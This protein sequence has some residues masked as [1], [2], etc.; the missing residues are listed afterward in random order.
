M[1]PFLFKHVSTKKMIFLSI[2]TT[3]LLCQSCAN[4][5]ETLPRET[6]N[7]APESGLLSACIKVEGKVSGDLIPNSTVSLYETSSVGYSIVMTE[8]R[9]LRP[10]KREA[11]NASKR[12]TFRCL[13]PGNYAFVIPSSS[14]NGAVGFPLPYEFDCPN[15]SLEIAF[16][17]GD[18]Q[19]AV[20]VFSIKNSS[21]QN[22]SVC[23]LDPAS[24]FAQRGSLYRKSPLD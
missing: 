2:I 9:T 12:F 4:P 3:I 16:Q 7:A 14:Y 10:V 13:F 22:R 17:G 21:S 6:Q 19:L 1:P 11:I 15:F 18:S 8:I 20:G 23:A 24:C 5:P